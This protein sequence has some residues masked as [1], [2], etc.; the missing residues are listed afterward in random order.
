MQPLIL[1][2]DEYALA[3]NKPNNVLVHHSDYS[4]IEG[5]KSLLELL[6]DLGIPRV[7]P[8]HRLD[9][10]T[11]GI[12]LLAKN[13]SDVA[14][15]QKLFDEQKIRKTYLALLRGHVDPAGIVDTPV[16]NDRGNYRE[17][18]THYRCIDHYELNVAVEPYETSRYSLVEMEPKT[19]RLHQLRVHANKIAH[20]IIGDHKHG[21][22]HHNRLFAEQFLL[23]DLFLHANELQFLHP[24]TNEE[25]IINA[26]LPAFWARFDEIRKELSI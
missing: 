13:R 23:P 11:S 22:R 24:F 5:E 16:R 9:R 25:I 8:L 3:V 10:K 26:P 14:S 6:K 7:Y 15:F 4:G 19:G 1:W 2:Q 12:V 21:N 20:P 18:L 17:A